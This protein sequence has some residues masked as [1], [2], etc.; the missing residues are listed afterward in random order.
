MV[1]VTEDATMRWGGWVAG[2]A[3]CLVGCTTAM[4][5]ERLRD[6]NQDGI[7]LFQ[8]GDYR[9]ARESFE[10]ALK[11]RPEDPALLYNVGECYDRLGASERAE[12]CYRACLEKVPNHSLCRHAL[13]NLL[14]HTGRQAE[15]E[16]MVAAW[17]KKEPNLASAHAEYGWLLHQMGD[18]PRAQA[19][20]QQALELDPHDP[21]ALTEMAL[22]YESLQR[23]DRAVVLYERILERD[24]TKVDVTN[25]VNF[26]LAKGAGRPHPD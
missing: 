11:L 23:P 25:R 4:D 3:L 2:L 1:R 16:Q 19:R 18:L 5:Q 21:R 14:V 8:H 22:V 10:A 17:L 9:D 24:P 20:L 7:R 26:L 6:Y 15:A 12:R 13:V